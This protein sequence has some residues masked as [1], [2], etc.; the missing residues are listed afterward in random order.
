[1]EVIV[2]SSC[3]HA[4]PSGPFTISDMAAQQMDPDRV[5]QQAR[6]TCII[7]GSAL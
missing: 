1:M 2:G 3:T 7:H 4:S 6:I 5:E